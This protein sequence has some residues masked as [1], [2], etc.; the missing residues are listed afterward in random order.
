MRREQREERREER[1]D[2]VP[3]MTLHPSNALYTYISRYLGNSGKPLTNG[4][5]LPR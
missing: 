4:E 5:Y 2:G 1:G 3:R